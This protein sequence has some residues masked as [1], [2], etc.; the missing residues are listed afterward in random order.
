MFGAFALTK[1]W[2][3]KLQVHYSLTV[4]L[5]PLSTCLIMNFSM[6]LTVS[7]ETEPFNPGTSE[8]LSYIVDVKVPKQAR[9]VSM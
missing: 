9:W 7:L 1:R 3:S 5:C 4:E 8:N 6:S 2:H